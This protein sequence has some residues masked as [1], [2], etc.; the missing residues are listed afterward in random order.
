MKWSCSKNIKVG[1]EI[2]LIVE[3]ETLRND[4]ADRTAINIIKPLI[5]HMECEEHY[6]WHFK[7][8]KED[9]NIL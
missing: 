4:N 2:V 1:V 6:L 7:C 9:T 3:K 5:N 8:Y